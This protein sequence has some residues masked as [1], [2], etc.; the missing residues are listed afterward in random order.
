M[1]FI[2]ITKGKFLT[3]I[4]LSIGFLCCFSSLVL[5]SEASAELLMQ[6]YE[7]ALQNDYEYQ[8][9]IADYQANKEEGPINRSGVLPSLRVDAER[10]EL[11]DA[12]TETNSYSVVLQQSLF[13]LPAWHAY[14]QGKAL[15][16]R[17]EVELE[18]SK[19]SMILRL[20]DA[21]LGALGALDSNRIAMAE[22]NAF[23]EQLAR[24]KKR[25]ELGLAAIAE[26]YEAQS[27]ADS[28]R[29][30]TLIANANVGVS[31]SSLSLLT[32]ES[33]TDLARLK[34]GFPVDKP[35]P[36]DEGDWI[37]LG[38]KENLEMKVAELT[39]KAAKANS[40]GK[41]AGHLPTITGSVSY[42]NS[43]I[44]ESLNS[45]QSN[46]DSDDTTVLL[47]LRI[48]LFNGGAIAASRRQAA[49]QKKSAEKNY[50]LA[51]KNVIR[52]V[53]SSHLNLLASIAGVEARKKI[54]E[55]TAKALKS[56]EAGYKIGTRNLVDVLN[57]QRSVF[58][59]E[60]NYSTA[61]YGYITN[62]LTLK[63]NAGVLSESDLNY[64]D[65]WL[66]EK[67]VPQER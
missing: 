54:I 30:S 6:S 28:A 13:D 26:V 64:L 65:Q 9:A 50:R 33:Y 35:T 41:A 37:D 25:Y 47:T 23:N 56:S 19:Q 1:L 8:A 24:S 51:E 20:A 44:N 66:N 16:Q 53:R 12:G 10:S 46:S 27:V 45:L 55:S 57:A 58:Q 14:K 18:Q 21:Y 4:K 31:L 48:P 38:L 29:A 39:W 60:Q 11:R 7:L 49:Y 62:G 3:S 17:A 52:T 5:Q 32:G 34:D 22:E 43:E 59:A 40:R 67:P 2:T 61:L 63:R 42:D 36:L 15:S